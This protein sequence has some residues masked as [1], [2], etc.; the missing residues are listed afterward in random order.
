MFVVESRHRT[1]SNTKESN[2][3]WCNVVCWC[4]LQQPQHG[5]SLCLLA[6][7]FFVSHCLLLLLPKLQAD[8]VSAGGGG[9]VVGVCTMC[10]NAN[11]RQSQ[12]KK[13]K[14]NGV[15]KEGRKERRAAAAEAAPQGSA[16]HGCTSRRESRL[17]CLRCS[18]AW[19]TMLCCGAWG[20]IES[21]EASQLPLTQRP[22][23]ALA[24]IRAELTTL[25]HDALPIALP[26]DQSLLGHDRTL[27]NNNNTTT[28]PP[29]P[30]ATGACERPRA[31]QQLS[32][33]GMRPEDRQAAVLL[34]GI[35]WRV[36]LEGLSRD[37]RA[38]RDDV[39]AQRADA[40]ALKQRFC[41]G[42]R[43]PTRT[44]HRAD[45]SSQKMLCPT[46]ALRCV[47]WTSKREAQLEQPLVPCQSTRLEHQRL[48]AWAARC[49]M[50]HRSAT[51]PTSCSVCAAD[52]QQIRRQQVSRW[53]PSHESLLVCGSSCCTNWVPA[54][55]TLAAAFALCANEHSTPVLLRHLV[56]HRTTHRTLRRQRCQPRQ[57]QAP[58][59]RA[60]SLF[61]TN[62][63]RQSCC[64]ALT[65]TR[66]LCLWHSKSNRV[67]DAMGPCWRKLMSCWVLQEW[68]WHQTRQ[69]E[70]AH[71]LWQHACN[72]GDSCTMNNLGMCFANGNSVEQKK[73]GKSRVF[74][75]TS[76]RFEECVWAMFNFAM[77]FD[78][79]TNNTK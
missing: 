41:G 49:T 4:L 24:R 61:F 31:V 70:K 71:K 73:H 59:R 32:E 51:T 55:H 30:E 79:T 48:C 8:P 58:H 60:P 27:L 39:A 28:H 69:E 25:C 5:M 23:E 66:C 53:H 44:H 67:V 77:H 7:S 18:T 47:A 72:M 62:N 11:G 43:A 33:H 17:S 14:R 45:A 65:L 12:K 40:A 34:R 35:R 19:C 75:A 42:R 37:C 15:P 74:V 2:G 38:W 20:S 29:P 13:N 68:Q 16:R 56:L 54:S 1:E 46:P 21:E 10:R 22:A 36:V 52:H 3:V 76:N 6:A 50:R 63:K 9:G 26:S 78:N 64:S 57:A